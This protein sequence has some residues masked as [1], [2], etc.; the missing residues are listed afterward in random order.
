VVK[1]Y[2]THKG[3]E[4]AN[5]GLQLHGGSG[6]TREWGIEQTVRD[7]RITLIYEGTNGVQALDLVGRKLGANGGR[8][9]FSF[10]G[11]IDEFVLASEGIDG[12]E[13]YLEGL[14][15]ARAQLQD[16]TMWLMQNG[17]SDFNNAGASSHDYLHLMGLTA[18]AYM[19]A[20]M[21]KIALE[22]KGSG[23][24]FYAAKLAT[25]RYFVERMLP[26]TAA[27]LAKVKTGS[28]AMMALSEAQ[29]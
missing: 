1:A 25:G 4:C 13:P 28:A 8:A 27:H 17:M 10:F 3:Y 9:V 11:E 22:K 18:L 24:P 29:F 21:A 7:C 5:L 12:L 6:F 14:K 20:R 15:T 2:L 16:G 23:D 26:D 19:W